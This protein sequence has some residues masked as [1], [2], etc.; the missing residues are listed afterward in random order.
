MRP[1]TNEAAKDAARIDHWIDAFLVALSRSDIEQL[2][3]LINQ[4]A[5]WRDVLAL[6]DRMVTTSGAASVVDRLVA[7]GAARNLKDLEFDQN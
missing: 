7:V 6:T 5:D 4:D 1:D 3:R 2:T